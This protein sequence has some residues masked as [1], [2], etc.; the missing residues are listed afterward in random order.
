M[1]AISHQVY[2]AIKTISTNIIIKLIMNY[3]RHIWPIK[4]QKCVASKL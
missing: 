3:K 2:V 1:L 4:R